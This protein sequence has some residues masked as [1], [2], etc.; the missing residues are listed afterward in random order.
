[1]LVSF[2]PSAISLQLSASPIVCCDRVIRQVVNV[3]QP[4][5]I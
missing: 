4:L 5:D 3:W 2:K 1:M